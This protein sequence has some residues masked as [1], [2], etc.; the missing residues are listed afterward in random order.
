MIAFTDAAKLAADL[1][2]GGEIDL[3]TVVDDLHNAAVAYGLIDL[4]G[5]DE[6]QSILSEAFHGR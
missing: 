2:A 6:I 3:Q 4:Y 1:V 5:V